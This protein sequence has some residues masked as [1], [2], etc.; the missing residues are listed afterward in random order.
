MFAGYETVL[1]CYLRISYAL[2]SFC[3]MAATPIICVNIVMRFEVKG[4]YRVIAFMLSV[5]INDVVGIVVF[6]IVTHS[7]ARGAPLGTTSCSIIVF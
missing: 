3:N 2:S 6:V 4:I 7:P 5:R 1:H